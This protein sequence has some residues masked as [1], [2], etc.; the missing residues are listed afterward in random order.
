MVWEGWVW[1]G[2][3]GHSLVYLGLHGLEHLPQGRRQE[4]PGEGEDQGA[5]RDGVHHQGPGGAPQT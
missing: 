5:Q 2:K 1:Y 4:R 3:V